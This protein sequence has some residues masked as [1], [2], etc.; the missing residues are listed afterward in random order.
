MGLALVLTGC[1]GGTDMPGAAS[2]EPNAAAT[3]TVPSP[4]T[5]AWKPKGE[6][7]R[8]P[9]PSAET[10]SGTSEERQVARGESRSAGD[11]ALLARQSGPKLGGCDDLFAAATLAELGDRGLVL[12]P[13]HISDATLAA[14]PAMHA[15]DLTN[16]AAERLDFSCFWSTPTAGAGSDSPVT[17]VMRGLDSAERERVIGGFTAEGY[18]CLDSDGGMRCTIESASGG[19]PSGVSAFLRDDV[20]L[21]TNWGGTPPTSYTPRMV[22]SIWG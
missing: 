5:S 8:E 21:H 20:W 17:R 14:G 1:A 2:A 6:R 22:S 16:L 3:T 9:S 4:T 10:D 18:T 13:A 11:S 15:Q 19:V 12:N 7:D